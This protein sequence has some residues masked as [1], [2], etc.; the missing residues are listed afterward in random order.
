[1]TSGFSRLKT[2]LTGLSLGAV[3]ALPAAAATFD[4]DIRGTF[5][6]AE[7]NGTAID[8]EFRITGTAI[9]PSGVPGPGPS[10]SVTAELDT[11]SL[12]LTYGGTVVATSLFNG[13]G[14]YGLSGGPIGRNDPAIYEFTQNATT[15]NFDMKAQTPQDSMVFAFTLESTSVWLGWGGEGRNMGITITQDADGVVQFG[16]SDWLARTLLKNQNTRVVTYTAAPEVSPIP[17]PAAGWLLLAGLGGL[18]LAA[19]RRRHA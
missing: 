10:N 17:L 19:R 3:L 18:G 8:Q 6:N 7:I 5:N 11:S 14:E 13:L 4:F 1:M 9:N 15:L 2:I 12:T 16:E